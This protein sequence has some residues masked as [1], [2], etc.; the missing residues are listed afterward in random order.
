MQLLA[1]S[2][3]NN[4]NAVAGEQFQELFLR[5]D[6]LQ[7]ASVIGVLVCALPSPQTNT[8]TEATVDV[9]FPTDST[10]DFTV[11]A[12]ANIFDA[13][14]A[15]NDLPPDIDSNADPNSYA[16]GDRNY[17]MWPGP[18]TAGVLPEASQSGKT[19][20]F[21]SGDLPNIPVKT[22]SSLTG[23]DADPIVYCFHT[24][25]GLTVGGATGAENISGASVTTKTST[26]TDINSTNWAFTPVTNDHI[27]VSATVPPNFTLSL[28]ANTNTFGTLST[29]AV[30]ST[31]GVAATISTN[32]K[33]GWIA[34][35]KDSN[36]GM[37]STTA[38]YTIDSGL[39]TD[40]PVF[41]TQ[42]YTVTSNAFQLVPS[43]LG[44]P[45]HPT[46]GY[47]LDIDLTSANSG[48]CTPAIDPLYDYSAGTDG[49][50]FLTSS[51][52]KR[53]ASCTGAV[54]ATS[55]GDTLTLIERAV[56]RPGTPAASDYS[57]TIYVVGAG[58]F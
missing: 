30:T 26:P 12:V 1:P 24:G 28:G 10:T 14:T 23:A 38:N 32:A 47:A 56:I 36:T 6:R 13:S 51:Y 54:P 53:A 5:P 40:S 57:D 45:A 55:D 2:F 16:A 42:Q 9:T 15:A 20:T 37:H 33:S 48:G 21:T 18:V 27:D 52:Y 50:G 19:V 31:A 46:E 11:S 8:D 7:A 34:W 49:G 39:K 29:T 22:L 43:A 3:S 35:V 58:N 17:E 4:A 25:A 44:P 41:P